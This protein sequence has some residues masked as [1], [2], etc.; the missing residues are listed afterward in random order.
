MLKVSR[1]VVTHAQSTR[2]THTH[3]FSESEREKDFYRMMKK[4][5]AI[6]H[7]VRWSKRDREQRMERKP[8]QKLSVFALHLREELSVN[9]YNQI[10]QTAVAKRLK[11][12]DKTWHGKNRGEISENEQT[13]GKEKT[14]N[15]HRKCTHTHSITNQREK[16]W[17]WTMEKEC[18]EECGH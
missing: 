5:F 18:H 4:L 14:K 8:Q 7:A 11:R 1:F 12:H 15:E 2:Q 10:W 9:K 3:T 17:K 6:A 16:D 13:N